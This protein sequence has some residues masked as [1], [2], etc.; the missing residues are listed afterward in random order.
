MAVVEIFQIHQIHLYQ[1]HLY[2]QQVEEW[3]EDNF[4]LLVIP[5][6]HLHHLREH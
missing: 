1:G 6:F 4:H 2:F 3:V 5:L